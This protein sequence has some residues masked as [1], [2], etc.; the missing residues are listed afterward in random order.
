MEQQQAFQQ[1]SKIRVTQLPPGALR[2]ELGNAPNQEEEGSLQEQRQ[3]MQRIRYHRKSRLQAGKAMTWMNIW[4][5]LLILMQ[6]GCQCSHFSPLRRKRQIQITALVAEVAQKEERHRT[7][8]KTTGNEERWIRCV[9]LNG[10]S[11]GTEKAFL[12]DRGAELGVF[13]GR[14]STY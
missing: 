6:T 12:E 11:C 5:M 9:M 3:R 4:M 7:R 14:S 1:S 13:L 10:S 8:M 2:S